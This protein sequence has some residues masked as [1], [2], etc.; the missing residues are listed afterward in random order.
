[1]LNIV[2][3]GPPGAGKGTQ[4][5]ILVEE[6]GLK[7]LST[8]ELLREEIA[9]ETELGK[10]AKSYI[11]KGELVPDEVVIDMIRKYLG[12]C[13]DRKGFL[14]DGFP[15]TVEQAKALDRLMAECGDEIKAMLCL[16]VDK[17]ELIRRL[18]A[19]A[20]VSGR[21][22]DQDVSVIEN[23]IAVYSQKTLPIVEYYKP[24]GK[25][26]EV[27]GTGSI[28]EIGERLKTLIRKL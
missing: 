13:G 6:F 11:D 17:E 24:Q 16:N 27:D 15:R 5:A 1:M 22:D 3:F 12:E 23:R 14:F 18:V 26:F 7:H 4:A 21:S 10:I 2:L 25:H 20:Q 9:K 19:R 28:E 8:G